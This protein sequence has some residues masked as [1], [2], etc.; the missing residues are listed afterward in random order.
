MGWAGTALRCMKQKFTRACRLCLNLVAR[1]SFPAMQH[2]SS[3]PFSPAPWFFF[4]PS[5]VFKLRCPEVSTVDSLIF[6]L[7]GLLETWISRKHESCWFS[8]DGNNHQCVW[9]RLRNHYRIPT[10]VSTSVASHPVSFCHMHVHSWSSSTAKSRTQIEDAKIIQSGWLPRLGSHTVAFQCWN[11]DTSSCCDSCPLTLPI[12]LPKLILKKLNPC[13][14]WQWTRQELSALGDQLLPFV[15]DFHPGEP[16]PALQTLQSDWDRQINHQTS[17]QLQTKG[18][19]TLGG[20]LLPTSS[21]HFPNSEQNDFPAPAPRPSKRA[22]FWICDCCS[23]FSSL[24][25]YTKLFWPKQPDVLWSICPRLCESRHYSGVVIREWVQQG[26]SNLVTVW[27]HGFP[28]SQTYCDTGLAN[29]CQ[30]V[31]KS[32]PRGQW[33]STDSLRE[34]T[35]WNAFLWKHPTSSR[36]VPP[37]EP[38]L[39]LSEKHTGDNTQTHHSYSQSNLQ[40]LTTHS[41]KYWLFLAKA[42]PLMSRPVCILCFLNHVF[43]THYKLS[44][45]Y[46]EAFFLWQSV[47]ALGPCFIQLEPCRIRTSPKCARVWVQTGDHKSM[48]GPGTKIHWPW[49]GTDF[50][51]PLRSP[52]ESPFKTPEHK[53]KTKPLDSMGGRAAMLRGSDSSTTTMT[54]AGWLNKRPRSS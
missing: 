38:T 43:L 25:S 7:D 1:V 42:T 29:R 31:S 44:W 12:K 51:P 50:N 13:A 14:G 48:T 24:L 22:N 40:L 16:F 5:I 23:R 21:G 39:F 11:L 6:T 30:E 53:E 17:Q 47:R 35:D 46:A 10:A 4:Q 8:S 52:N 19:E 34:Y 15:S 20:L 32:G 28:K 9:R 2:N 37:N 45:P 26:M 36:I 3:V 27:I 18:R 41:I 54:M 33:V 49:K